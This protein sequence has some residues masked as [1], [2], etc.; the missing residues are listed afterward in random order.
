MGYKNREIEVKL[1]ISSNRITRVNINNIAQ[2][3]EQSL[4]HYRKVSGNST[5]IYY[6]SPFDT[7]AFIRLRK[8]GSNSEMT[9]KIKDRNTNINRVE[10]DLQIKDPKQA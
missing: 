8:S 2:I 9:T 6:H 1:K 3:I 7:D 10:I 4:I 5:D